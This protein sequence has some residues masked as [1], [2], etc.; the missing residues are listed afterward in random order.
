MSLSYIMVIRFSDA[1]V[2]GGYVNPEGETPEAK[3]PYVR[4]I[5]DLD[6]STDADKQ[7]VFDVIGALNNLCVRMTVDGE[8]DLDESSD[9]ATFIKDLRSRTNMHFYTAGA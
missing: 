3:G 8:G 9:S 5:S 6:V 4:A 2:P 1:G 7:R